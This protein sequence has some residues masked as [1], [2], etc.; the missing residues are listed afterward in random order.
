MRLSTLSFSRAVSSTRWPARARMC[1]RIRPAST[2]GEEVVAEQKQPTGSGSQTEQQK[3]ADE[4]PGVLEAGGQALAVA[5]AH[6]L[7]T[8]REAA[9]EARKD[10]VARWRI[11]RRDDSCSRYIASVGTSV[12]ESR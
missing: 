8:V 12:R 10:V 9:L 11:P 6:A 5:I 2:T 7:E 4:H 1:R 3:H